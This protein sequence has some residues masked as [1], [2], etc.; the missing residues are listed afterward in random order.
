MPETKPRPGGLSEQQY[1][2]LSQ[3]LYGGLGGG[4]VPPQVGEQLAGQLGVIRPMPEPER[5][6]EMAPIPAQAEQFFPASFLQNPNTRSLISNALQQSGV[7]FPAVP[8]RPAAP[9]PFAGIAGI[10][11]DLIG[12]LPYQFRQFF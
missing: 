5:G 9:R 6:P 2:V 7:E 12:M 3:I 10:R 4:V 1:D 11:P 8:Q